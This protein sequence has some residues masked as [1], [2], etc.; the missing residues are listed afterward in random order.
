MT[1]YFRRILCLLIWNWTFPSSLNRKLAIHL[2]RKKDITGF[3]GIYIYAVLRSDD[4]S[5]IEDVYFFLT[6]DSQIEGQKPLVHG[7]TC[8]IQKIT[9]PQSSSFALKQAADFSW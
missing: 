6:L 9:F 4:V 5:M 2:P 8:S 7:N 1:E 3:I